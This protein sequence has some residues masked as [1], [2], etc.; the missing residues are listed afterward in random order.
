MTRPKKAAGGQYGATGRRRQ[1]GALGARARRYYRWAGS[2]AWLG[3]GLG[4]GLP[5]TLALTLA[6]TLTLTLALI[7]TL[8]LAL[9]LP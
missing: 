1:D 9:T 2:S 8:T 3:L 6:L 5:L 7:L 4:L